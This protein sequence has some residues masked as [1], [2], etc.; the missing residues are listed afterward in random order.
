MLNAMKGTTKKSTIEKHFCREKVINNSEDHTCTNAHIEV[1]GQ[2]RTIITDY[3]RCQ[4]TTQS[5]SSY[6]F[7]DTKQHI[8][9]VD[10]ID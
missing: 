1:Q 2:F 8:K 5:K 4:F 10:I 7:Q 3:R 6:S 9:M